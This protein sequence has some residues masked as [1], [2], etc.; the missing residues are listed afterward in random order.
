MWDQNEIF[1]SYSIFNQNIHS[2]K[3]KKNC[4]ICRV[5]ITVG[6]ASTYEVLKQEHRGCAGLQDSSNSKFPPFEID[7]CEFKLVRFDTFFDQNL[8]FSKRFPFYSHALEH[9]KW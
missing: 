9:W 6:G 8:L 3:K 4:L 2:Q 7:W 5:Y 1:V